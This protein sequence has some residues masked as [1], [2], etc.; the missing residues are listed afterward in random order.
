MKDEWKLLAFRPEHALIRVVCHEDV[1]LAQAAFAS[2][3]GLG[4]ALGRQAW[5]LF[6][7]L[8]VQGFPTRRPSR[9]AR[10]PGRLIHRHLGW[11][12]PAA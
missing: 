8:P 11:W 7:T 5:N 4:Y 9:A 10:A 1:V 6:Q 12:A 2:G 3:S